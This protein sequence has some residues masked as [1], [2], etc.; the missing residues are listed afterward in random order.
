[1]LLSGS[2]LVTS[3]GGVMLPVFSLLLMHNPQTGLINCVTK[4]DYKYLPE[5]YPFLLALLAFMQP[6]LLPLLAQV[7]ETVLNSF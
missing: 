5:L 3:H 4:L 7:S 1:M 6:R 2:L